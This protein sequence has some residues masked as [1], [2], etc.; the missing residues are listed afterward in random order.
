M[1]S[2]S[3]RNLG[4]NDILS[5][6]L[7]PDYAEVINER[8]RS[9]RQRRQRFYAEMSDEHKM[10]FI[11]GEVVMHSPARNWHLVTKMHVVALLH[12]HVRIHKLGEIRNEKCLCV[13]PRND[14]EPDV[15]F[16][17][18]EKAALLQPDTLKFP[19]PDLAVEVLSESTEQ[20]DRGVKFTDFEAH[21]VREYWISD[22][23]EQTV[24]Q[25]VLRDGAFH[26]AMKSATGELRSEIVRGFT[27]PVAAI[28]NEA[29]NLAALRAML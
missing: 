20:R 19:V 2:M 22:P 23:E 6:P 18:A 10:E 4:L 12:M 9:E 26:L 5:S 13:F 3:T 27:V 16:F 7:L 14:Y 21:G 28:F 1:R 24:E 25:Y 11:E 8:L 29:A 17:G 15:V